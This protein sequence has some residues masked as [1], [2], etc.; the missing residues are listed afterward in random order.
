[1]QDK[2]AFEDCVLDAAVLKD[3]A[4]VRAYVGI[5]AGQGTVPKPVHGAP[6]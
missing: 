1:M 4:A 6:R 3:E 2:Q 5:A